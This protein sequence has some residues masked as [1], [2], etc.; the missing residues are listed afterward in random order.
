[1]R[2]RRRND[3]SEK[4]GVCGQTRGY[5]SSLH[6]YF[7][8]VLLAST[9]Q[10]GARPRRDATFLEM[11]SGGALTA[12]L[13]LSAV[14]VLSP[15]LSACSACDPPSGCETINASLDFDAAVG[16]YRLALCN[17]T[18]CFQEDVAI[19]IATSGVKRARSSDLGPNPNGVSTIT[20]T[21]SPNA[22]GTSDLPGFSGPAIAGLLP[23]PVLTSD[24]CTF[25]LVPS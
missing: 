4:V 2:A 21:L 10:D 18:T 24:P 17:G 9:R 25:S 12:M 16:V 22:T 11:A 7:P 1:V 8:S 13:T 23:S 14:L 15:S 6:L 5:R 19:D 3:A 20:C